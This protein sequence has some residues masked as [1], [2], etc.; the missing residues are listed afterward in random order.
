M[1]AAYVVPCHQ[2]T[3]GRSAS[4]GPLLMMSLVLLMMDELVIDG[5]GGGT[6]V[7]LWVVWKLEADDD[8]ESREL[9]AQA[10]A[11]YQP[12]INAERATGRKKA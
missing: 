4:C 7:C 3:C 6:G 1:R 2:W 5:C 8:S 11:A 9:N 12:T 10:A